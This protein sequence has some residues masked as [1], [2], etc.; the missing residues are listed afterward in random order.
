MPLGT[1]QSDHV[2]EGFRSNHK[3]DCWFRSYAIFSIHP[4][5][6]SYSVLPCVWEL[7]VIRQLTHHL[8]C[9]WIVAQGIQITIRSIFSSTR[10]YRIEWGS[11]FEII[12]IE[13]SHAQ[14][15]ANC[16]L[17]IHRFLSR[18]D[19]WWEV[20]LG[21][22]IPI[23]ITPKQQWNKHEWGHVLNR[24]SAVTARE[25]TITQLASLYPNNRQRNGYR[26]NFQT[27]NHDDEQFV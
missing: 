23:G 19:Q 22:S 11:N 8:S 25:A 1:L 15:V 3:I 27:M 21:L 6:K 7:A 13:Q 12:H 20:W 18:R 24:T 14:I 16:I 2:L 26:E 4:A 9:Y 17:L 5:L 10:E